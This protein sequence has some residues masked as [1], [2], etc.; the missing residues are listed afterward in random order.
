MRV[1]LSL[2]RVFCRPEECICVCVVIGPIR[3]CESRV[4]VQIVG[5]LA[6]GLVRPRSQ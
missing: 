4:A 1:G 2:M 6:F 5:S 3:W